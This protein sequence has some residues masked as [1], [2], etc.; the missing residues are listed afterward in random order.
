[1][2]SSPPLDNAP[3]HPPLP[4]TN[5]L[6]THISTSTLQPSN[7]MRP[8]RT[9]Q[10]RHQLSPAARPCSDWATPR[11]SF[12]PGMYF[13]DRRSKWP[14]SLSI[15]HRHC[16]KCRRTEGSRRP[17]SWQHNSSGLVPCRHCRSAFCVSALQSILRVWPHTFRHFPLR[18]HASRFVT[19]N[20]QTILVRT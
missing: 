12:Y 20:L 18:A 16:R 7:S 19:Y 3:A 6:E 8:Q 4:R 2:F 10:S 5:N 13:L 14:R 9:W 1:M 11:R 15:L 17:N